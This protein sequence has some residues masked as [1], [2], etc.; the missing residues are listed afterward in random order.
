MFLRKSK[1]TF[2]KMKSIREVIETEFSEKRRVHTYGVV[3]TAKELAVLYGA[4]VEKAETAALYHD[5]F[6]GKQVDILNY[7]VKHL[8]L[9][10]PYVDNANL[11]HS[12][13]AV[14][15]M[16]NEYG[17]K[18]EDVLNAVSFHTTGRANMSLLEKV[19]FIA[20]AIEPNRKYP[21]VEK[22]RK[23]AREDLDRACLA[24]LENTISF[25]ES[26]GDYLD[27]DTLEARDYL[28]KELE[29]G[30]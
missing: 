5:L 25:V 10:K 27:P 12:K 24:S 16:K 3:E 2:W 15:V 28:L 9:G 11:S 17:I 26:K 14:H 6:R 30:N 23:L 21:G 7:Y 13:I 20:D 4:D 8:N 29:S 18:D 19:V 1:G 22:L